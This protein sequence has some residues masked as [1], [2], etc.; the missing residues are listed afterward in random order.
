MAGMLFTPPARISLEL[1][2]STSFHFKK[3]DQKTQKPQNKKDQNT[4]ETHKRGEN[5]VDLVVSL[6]VGSQ[7]SELN[8]KV[9]PE[10]T[11]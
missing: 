4:L 9:Q 6:P 3:T 10:E 5:K 11:H 1:T 8:P 7:S 2:I